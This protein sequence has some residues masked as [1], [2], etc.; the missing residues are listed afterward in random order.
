VS[1]EKK[2]KYELSVSNFKKLIENAEILTD[3]LSEQ[4]PELPVDGNIT[5]LFNSKRRPEGKRI[6]GLIDSTNKVL[7]RNV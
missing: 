1:A 6:A 5:Y 3:L 4:M 2:E 7:A